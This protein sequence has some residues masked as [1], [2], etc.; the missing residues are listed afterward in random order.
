[1]AALDSMYNAYM[2]GSSHPLI[3]IWNTEYDK[4][5]RI[6]SVHSDSSDLLEQWSREKYDNID[7]F[8]TKK[9]DKLWDYTN[10]MVNYIKW[11]SDYDERE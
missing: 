2:E 7:V 9:T 11:D 3:N 4:Y 5:A 1:M 6:C 10:D 8:P